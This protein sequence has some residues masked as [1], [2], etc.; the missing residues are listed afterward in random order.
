MLLR[1]YLAPW[2]ALLDA[3]DLDLS[4]FGH[5]MLYSSTLCAPGL[6]NR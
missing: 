6:L 3:M 4:R 2:R 5:L 1:A